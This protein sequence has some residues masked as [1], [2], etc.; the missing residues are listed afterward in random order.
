MPC[1]DEE[2]K[3]E[4]LLKHSDLTDR[5][6]RVAVTLNG[7]WCIWSLLSQVREMAATTLSG[8]LQ[9]NFLTMDG[10]MQ[11]HFEQLCKMRLPKKRKRDPGTVA[12]TI[13]SGGKKP[14]STF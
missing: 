5:L 8:L 10:P 9:C 3:F 2:I 12:D 7:N 13:P 6:K 4:T 11:T 1:D 14:S